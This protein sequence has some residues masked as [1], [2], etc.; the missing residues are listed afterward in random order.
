MKSCR[1]CVPSTLPQLLSSLGFQWPCIFLNWKFR[2]KS[3]W[4]FSFAGRHLVLFRQFIGT[5]RWEDERVR[6]LMWVFVFNSNALSDLTYKFFQIFIPRVIGMYTLCIIAFVIYA[7]RIPERWITGK[8][9]YGG[10]SHNWWHIFILGALYYWHNSGKLQLFFLNVK[11]GFSDFSL[12][13]V[14]VLLAF[15]FVNSELK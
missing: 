3:K 9:D 12:F 10:H 2:M 11:I 14:W 8:V 7:L 6:W 13:R 5:L 1:S 4:P 15:F